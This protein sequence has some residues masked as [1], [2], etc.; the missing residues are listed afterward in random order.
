MRKKILDYTGG[1]T[2]VSVSAGDGVETASTVE[3]YNIGHRKIIYHS[4]DSVD[5]IH[6]QY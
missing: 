3:S 5:I 2:D 1:G 4:Y 6:S